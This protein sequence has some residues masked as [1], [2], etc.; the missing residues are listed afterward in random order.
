MNPLE[1]K[2][3]AQSHGI[4][5]VKMSKTQLIHAIQG[6]EDH[7]MCFNTGNSTVCGGVSCPW[8]EDCV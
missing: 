2:V 3:V 7:D 8:R 4:K 6:A 1:I 5:T